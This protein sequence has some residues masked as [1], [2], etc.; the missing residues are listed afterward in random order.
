MAALLS[1]GCTAGYAQQVQPASGSEA[2]GSG[3]S[4]S[5]TLG[6]AFYTSLTGPN[7]MLDQGIQNISLTYQVLPITLLS[8]KTTRYDAGSVLVTWQ[9]ASEQQNDYFVLE[10]SFDGS[11]FTE[12][13]RVKGQ[14]TSATVSNYKFIDHEPRAGLNYYRLKQTDFDHSVSYSPITTIQFSATGTSV[15]VF[16]NP[17]SGMVTVQTAATGNKTYQ[18]T[19]Y[20]GNLIESKPVTSGQMQL[21]MSSL[22]AS[23]YILNILQGNKIIESFKITKH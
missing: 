16:P 13:T 2:S 15:S 20:S 23:T 6:Q 1:A 22:P 9:T 18:L 7:G 12:I 11:T 3:G 17:T 8:F 5:Y 21:N 19:T 4:V 14:G 10:R